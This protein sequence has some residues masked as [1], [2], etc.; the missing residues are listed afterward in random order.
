MGRSRYHVIKDLAGPYFITCTVVNWIGLFNHSNIVEI[1]LDSF[2]FLI[3]AKRLQV[4]GWVI[5]ENHLHAVVSSPDMEKEIGD[6]KSWTARTIIDQLKNDSRSRVLEQ[7]AL[8]KNQHKHSQTYQ[9]WQDGYHPEL[10]TSRE[11]LNIKLNYIHDNPVRSGYVAFPEHWRYSSY[12]D[13]HGETG[14]LP[15]E[16]IGL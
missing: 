9:V 1:V 12:P 4:H 6:F 13:Y 8:G 2:R 3:A 7:L 15:V 14:L 11:A 10:L 5:M 16:I